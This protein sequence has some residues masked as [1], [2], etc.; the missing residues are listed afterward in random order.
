MSQILISNALVVSD[1]RAEHG[2]VL[3][4]GERIEKVGSGLSAPD[5]AK[6]VDA[7]GKWLL[8]GMIDDQVHFREPGLTHKGDLASESSAAVAGGITSFMEMPNTKPP[9][10]TREALAA[11]Y[12]LAAGRAHAN[13]AFYFGAANDNLEEV[14]RLQPD[15]ACGVKV[16]MGASTGNMLVD[17]PKILASIFSQCPY[18]IATHCEDTP[19]ILAQEQA[20]RERYG[21][22]VP[23]SAHPLIRSAEACYKST[24]LAVG[25]ARQYGSKLHVLHMTT[26]RELEFFEPGPVA[27]KQITGEACVH[28]LWFSDEDYDALGAQLKCN[29]AVKTAADRAALREAVVDGR[30]NIIATDHAPH[31]A[32]EKARKYFAA[33]AG[34]P[35]VQHAVLIVLELVK[36]GV[37]DLPT[38]VERMSHAPA[39]RYGVIDRGH[40]A[41]G[42]YADLVLVDP[43]VQT[44]VEVDKLYYKC[45]W[46]PLEGQAFS[47]RVV[48][49]WV[50]GEA[51]YHL[52]Q[53]ATHAR[54]QRLHFRQ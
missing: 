11:K 36:Q 19:M 53:L 47:H 29:P 50:N 25:L 21:E 48:T 32:D 4:S 10:T 7:R 40:I 27:G 20:Y 41:E 45:G 35:L 31:T 46:S 39:A 38:A 23:F 2:D 1:G 18:L 33:P 42:Q 5:G 24:E 49:T 34:L 9:A 44:H 8:P 30:L 54:G 22:D 37:L 13:Y 52:N 43:D 14:L 16:F 26:A 6:V 3:I 28:H 12:D 17:N 15:E 51:A